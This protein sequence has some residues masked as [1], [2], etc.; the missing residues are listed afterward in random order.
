MK[1]QPFFL[2]LV[3]LIGCIIY[4]YNSTGDKPESAMNLTPKQYIELVEKKKL[5]RRILE[6]TAA[7]ES[8]EQNK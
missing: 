8:A 3:V 4:L 7:K 2:I 1:S 5:E 6:K